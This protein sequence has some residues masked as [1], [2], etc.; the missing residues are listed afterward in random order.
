MSL[1]QVHVFYDEESTSYAEALASLA[2]RAYELDLCLDPRMLHEALMR[3]EAQGTTAL[4]CGVSI[5]HAKSE[6][7]LAPAVLVAR[8][9]HMVEWSNEC[10]VQVA[11]CLLMP[12][13]EEG[14]LHLKNL[15]KIA[16]LLSEE[17]EAAALLSQKDLEVVRQKILGALSEG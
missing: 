16:R 5:P 12:E 7:V 4:M 1:S 10:G 9:A 3:R 8:F 13:G 15:S 11:I 2:D 17:D 14:L 6:T